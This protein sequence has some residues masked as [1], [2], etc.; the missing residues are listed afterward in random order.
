MRAGGI[1]MGLVAAL[2]LAAPG[3]GGTKK[4]SHT[5][6][7]VSSGGG[8]GGGDPCAGGGGSDDGDMVS[9]ES[10]DEIN[11]CFVKKRPSVARCY[12]DAVAS[13]KLDKKAKGRISLEMTIPTQGKPKSVKVVQ[14]TLGSDVV[15][16]CVSKTIEGWE[17][18]PPNVETSFAFSYDFEPE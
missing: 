11:S 9:S 2:A 8:E 14:D 10:M 7:D 5:A 12:D 3:C 18:P 6:E 4:S 13:G 16:R 1:V 15:A 17:I